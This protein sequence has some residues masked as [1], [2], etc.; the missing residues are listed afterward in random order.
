MTWHTEW[1]DR[2][3]PLRSITWL[4]KNW[5]RLTCLPWRLPVWSLG[6]FDL[7]SLSMALQC[8]IVRIT[9]RTV[10]RL[11]QLLFMKDF[12]ME[13]EMIHLYH[14]KVNEMLISSSV[15]CSGWGK[16]SI[17]A[18]VSHQEVLLEQDSWKIGWRRVPRWHWGPGQRLV[19]NIVLHV[20][21]PGAVR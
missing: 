21:V 16:Y 4:R 5:I 18:G 7:A 3:G 11:G 8:M 20:F 17:R 9:F 19:A 12:E 14:N 2:W 13:T 1:G 10:R 6:G 15:W